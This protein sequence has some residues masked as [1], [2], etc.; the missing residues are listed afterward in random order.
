[1]KS[2]MKLKEVRPQATERMTNESHNDTMN[3][4]MKTLN[5]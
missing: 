3:R 5:A 1:M 2:E 4:K